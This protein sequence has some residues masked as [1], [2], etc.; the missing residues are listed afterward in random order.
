MVGEREVEVEVEGVGKLLA[1]VLS[2]DSVC[3]LFLQHQ[4]SVF[5]Q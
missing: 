1:L 2:R 3:V 5:E 4:Q